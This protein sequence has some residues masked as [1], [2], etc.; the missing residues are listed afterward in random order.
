M[1]IQN[2]TAANPGLLLSPEQLTAPLDSIDHDTQCT[3]SGFTGRFLFLNEGFTDIIW[4]PPSCCSLLH[5]IPGTGA[6]PWSQECNARNY[7]DDPTPFRRLHE[8]HQVPGLPQEAVHYPTSPWAQP[9]GSNCRET[10]FVR[11]G[12]SMDFFPKQVLQCF[13]VLP[14][15]GS[16]FALLHLASVPAALAVS[17]WFWLHEAFNGGHGC[18]SFLFSGCLRLC[19]LSWPACV[20]MSFWSCLGLCLVFA[21]VFSNLHGSPM[22][23]MNH[24]IEYHWIAGAA[25]LRP[26][27]LHM[28]CWFTKNWSWFKIRT[29]FGATD[30]G[31]LW[32]ENHEKPWYWLAPWS[33]LANSPA[34][35]FPCETRFHPWGWL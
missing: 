10:C 4:H 7:R 19:W 23:R 22:K 33:Q 14:E 5:S 3:P 13:T 8:V 31:Q 2:K 16:Y 6:V 20:C 17:G 27:F 1:G 9:A 12:T 28:S 15:M 35:G 32:S 29:H 11:H 21:G 26:E 25:V 34:D 24:A 30:S 18:L